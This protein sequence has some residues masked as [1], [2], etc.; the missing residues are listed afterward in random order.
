MVSKR[1]GLTIVGPGA[2]GPAGEDN[3]D[4]PAMLPA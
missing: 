2:G 1:P 3:G 4:R